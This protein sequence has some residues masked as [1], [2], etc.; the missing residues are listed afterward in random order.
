MNNN[1][2]NISERRTAFVVLFTLVVM[3]AELSVGLLS[4]SMALTADG[5]HMGSHVLVLG[6][7]WA[8]YILVRRLKARGLD[9]YDSDRILNLSAWTSGVFLLLMAIFI[10][11]EA[12]ERLASPDVDISTT[13]ALAVAGVGLIANLIC[14]SALHNHHQDLNS[15]AAYLH[16]LS[17][18]LTEIGV[19]VGLICAKLWNITFID[20]LVAF[21]AAIVV[22]RW[23]IQLL[24]T[25]GKALIENRP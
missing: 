20:G 11:V 18:V 12:A 5:V 7:N 22:I 24:R 21:V 4:H 10:I 13:E 17:D 1:Y 19:I 3:I 23:A 6:L 14:A 16:I 25:T 2:T 8:A 9:K 15:R